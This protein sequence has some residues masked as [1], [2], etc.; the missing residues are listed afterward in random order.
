MNDSHGSNYFHQQ[1]LEEQTSKNSGKRIKSKFEERVLFRVQY[2]QVSNRNEETDR[3][4]K[5]QYF[6]NKMPS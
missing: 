6:A 3:S 4:S 2:F 1:K 5:F